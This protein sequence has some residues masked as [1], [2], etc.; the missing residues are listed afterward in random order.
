MVRCNA[1]EMLSNAYP[2]EKIGERRDV[3]SYFLLKQQNAIIDLL[4][5]PCPQVRI[6]AIKVCIL[7]NIYFY[8]SIVFV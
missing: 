7:N 6:A 1:V 3:I 8:L 5:D 4:S 2:L